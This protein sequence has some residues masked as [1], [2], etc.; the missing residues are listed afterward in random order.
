M[1]RIKAP[2]S[3]TRRVARSVRS[4]V[5]GRAAGCG[6]GNPAVLAADL[7][8]HFSLPPISKVMKDLEMRRSA[9]PLR[10]ICSGLAPSADHDSRV[11]IHTGRL[12]RPRSESD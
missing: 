7:N 9:N 3:V 11:A 1:G 6:V 10:L 8:A 12:M 4:L 2:H 5:A